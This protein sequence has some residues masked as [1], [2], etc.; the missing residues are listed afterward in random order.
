VRAA[1]GKHGAVDPDATGAE[2]RAQTIEGLN[3]PAAGAKGC[4]RL[5][6]RQRAQRGAAV[7]DDVPD[8]QLAVVVQ[9]VA[10]QAVRPAVAMPLRV[11]PMRV[12]VQ[13]QFVAG[14][15]KLLQLLGHAVMLGHQARVLAGL[16]AHANQPG[17]VNEKHQ[18]YAVAP[19]E[20]GQR[21]SR[22]DQAGLRGA[23]AAAEKQLV[24]QRDDDVHGSAPHPARRRR[25]AFMRSA[26][27]PSATRERTTE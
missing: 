23:A 24:V 13:L 14:D 22:L 11:L 2:R 4:D 19:S 9:A 26:G 15:R 10:V 25:E 27:A 16:F 18:R 17:G 5:P 21:L 1:A 6:R 8:L 20:V 7:A 12:H 3:A